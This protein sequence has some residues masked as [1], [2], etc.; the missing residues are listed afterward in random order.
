MTGTE[1]AGKRQVQLVSD[2]SQTHALQQVELTIEALNLRIARLA[3]ALGV[4][5]KNKEDVVRVMHRPAAQVLTQERRIN[6]ERRGSSRADSS[7]ERRTARSWEELR[8]LMVLR[9]DAQ[10]DCVEQVGL[11]ATRKI[12]SEVKE[13]LMR[14]GFKPGDDGMDL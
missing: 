11:V 5:L 6:T 2:N 12:L 7:T 9:Y 3:I 8:G 1:Q 10:K 4:S 14:K 13:H